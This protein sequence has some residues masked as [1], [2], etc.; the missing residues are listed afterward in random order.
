MKRF[1]LLW[2]ALAAV[3]CSFEQSPSDRLNPGTPL[4]S[5]EFSIDGNNWETVTVPHSYN[6]LD[7][8]SEQYYRGTAHYRTVIPP[9]PAEAPRFIL[10]EGAAQQCR[11]ILNGEEIASHK[12]GYTPFTVNLTGKL[13]AQRNILE[14]V[15]DNHEDVELI[16]VSS[17]FNKNGGLHNPV[18]LL[19]Y[20]ESYFSPEAYG[21][22]RIHVTQMEVSDS[23][24]VARAETKVCGKASTVRWSLADASGNE[25]LQGVS[26][27]GADGIA[28]WDF[29]LEAPHLWNGLAD[30]Y[31]YTVTASMG[32]GADADLAG[33]E[34]GFRYFLFDPDK[35]FYLNGKPYPLRGISMH[36]DTYGKASALSRADFDRD[37]DIVRELGCNFL[38]LAHYPHNDYAF[39]LCDRLGIVVQTEIPWVNVCGERA[40][41]EYF[42]NIHSQ[43]S[44]MI[45]SLYNHPSIV[46][47]GMWNELDTWGNKEQF[48]GPFDA[49]KVRDE[50][51]R[52]YDH[53]KGLDSTRYVGL[54]ECSVLKR[55]F[56]PELKADFMSENRYQGWYYNYNTF[57]KFTAEMDFVHEVRGRACVAEYGYGVNP[58]CHTWKD[59]DIRRYKDDSLHVEEYGNR[60]HEAIIQQI[61]D[62]PYLGF[63][64][65][66]I[67]FDFPVASRHEGFVDSQDG[68]EFTVNEDRKYMNDKGIVTRDRKVRKD[69]FYL[70]KSLWNTSEETVYI[71]GRRLQAR[72]AGEDFVLTVYSNAPW[73]ALYRDGREVVRMDSTGENTGVIWKFP[74]TM[75]DSATTFRVVSPTGATDEVTFRAL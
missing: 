22:Y 14:V 46:F 29:S 49:V 48:Q 65:I 70:Y 15:C 47:W 59:G 61:T 68:V 33:A 44:E 21:P 27:P 37:Y 74:A 26:E 50:T 62:L 38:R 6:A 16:P 3:S 43:M 71:S 42:D 23:A 32:E 73:L 11:V 51:A 72:P 57:D 75:G 31:L 5:W 39:R 17:D 9:A 1:R 13:T 28:V 41:P 55:E 66:W 7:G 40:T 18:W 20:G 25:V 58:F 8:H 52:L 10:F 67:M 45:T 69:V 60:A 12:G 34:V 36:Q 63:T 2:L 56:Y 24:A 64:A 4:S 53:A 30:P 19:E 54:T 35:G